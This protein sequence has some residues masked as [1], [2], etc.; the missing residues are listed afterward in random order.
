MKQTDKEIT[1]TTFKLQ[2]GDFIHMEGA[3]MFFSAP[4]YLGA[5][6]F[7]AGDSL[8]ATALSNGVMRFKKRSYC[9][10]NTKEIVFSK[11]NVIT[12]KDYI[13]SQV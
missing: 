11:E 1:V 9:C 7:I 8:E 2:N 4:I 6:T 3:N 5:E 13:D 10:V 12:V